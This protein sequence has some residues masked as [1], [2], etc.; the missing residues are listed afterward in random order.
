MFF[1]QFCMKTTIFTPNLGVKPDFS[2]EW[3]LNRQASNLTNDGRRRIHS[4][5]GTQDQA[6]RIGFFVRSLFGAEA[7]FQST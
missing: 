4:N 5:I 6:D 3:V 1:G 7:A 2:A